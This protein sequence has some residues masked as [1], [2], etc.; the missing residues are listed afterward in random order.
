MPA[1]VVSILAFLIYYIYNNKNR[2]TA[3]Y[4]DSKNAL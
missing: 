3:P 2:T 4:I 1:K